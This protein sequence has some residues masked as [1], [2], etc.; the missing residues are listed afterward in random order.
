MTPF[1]TAFAVALTCSVLVGGLLFAGRSPSQ[2]P[3]SV[4]SSESPARLVVHEWGTFTSFSGSD[5]INIGYAPDN[6][7]LPEFVY[8][9][10]DT[11]SKVSRLAREG[12]VS[13]ETPV[14]YFYPDREMAVRVRVDFPKGWVTEWYPF[15]SGAP[16][17]G[18]RGIRWDVRLIPN[19]PADFPKVPERREAYEHARFT[20]AAPVQ[21]EIPVPNRE[22][23]ASVRGGNIVQREKFLFYRGVG[24]FPTPVAVKALGSGQVRVRNAESQR[25]GGLV[26]VN[27]RDGKLGFRAIPDLDPG[28]ETT[29][30][31]PSADGNS[32]VL[33]EQFVRRLTAAGLYEKEAQAMVRTW[34]RAWFRE[35]GTRVFYTVP[36]ART[37]E[38]L[39]LA[40][41]PKPTDV[42]RVL[43]GRHDFLTPEQEAEADRQVARVKAARLELE[44]A[45]RALK[46]L[47]RFSPQAAQQSENRIDARRIGR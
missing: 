10:E 1:R 14:L 15:A 36:R 23:N 16:K 30:S 3:A 35:E 12:T 38:L 27:V 19:G 28:A 9:Q 46:K 11:M 33:G 24:T 43:V 39:P 37:D 2:P 8:Y 21:A 17:N 25:L 4:P 34:E 32:K 22:Q 45:D 13:M 31:I 41:D 42:V 20:D 5:G 26:L 7:D 29:L 40:I 47:G 6:T 44:A 18:E